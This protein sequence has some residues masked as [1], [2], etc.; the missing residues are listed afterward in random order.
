MLTYYIEFVSLRPQRI[1]IQKG[2]KSVRVQYYGIVRE[3]P[4]LEEN[5]CNVFNNS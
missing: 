5:Q 3:D 1:C 2:A 4:S